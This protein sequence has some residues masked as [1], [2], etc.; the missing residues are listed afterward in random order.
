MGSPEAIRM[1][2]TSSSSS[3]INLRFEIREGGTE[4]IDDLSNPIKNAYEFW[5]RR[6]GKR[7]LNQFGRPFQVDLF[8]KFAYCFC[9]VFHFI[10][11]LG[12][13]WDFWFSFFLEEEKKRIINLWD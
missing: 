11:R 6:Y 13:E 5:R 4:S 2:Y 9:F 10:S 3:S 7:D 12:W 1:P 8:R